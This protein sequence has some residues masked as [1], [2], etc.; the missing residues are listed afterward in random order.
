VTGNRTLQR[1]ERIL[2]LVPWLLERP[3][4]TVDEVTE[5]FGVS[6]AELAADLD[7][8]GYCGLPGYGGGDLIEASIVGDRVTVRLADY[9]RR[10]LRLSVREAVTLLLAA[11]T[12]AAVPGLRE[13]AELERAG[14]KLAG[15][16]GAPAALAIDLKAPGD[17]HL[18]PLRDAVERRRVVSLRYR[19]RSKSE[20]TE[21][22]VE[23]W[24]VVGSQGAWYLQGWC[25]LARGPRDFRLDRIERLAV[26]GADAGPVP[27]APASPPPYQPRAGDVEVVL[28][29]EQ[30]AWWLPD[31][32]V[33][34]AV[35]DRGQV[36]RVRLRTGE[37]EWL[38]RLAL[39]HGSAIRVVAP[40]S[41]RV[42][43][44]D[45]ADQTLRHYHNEAN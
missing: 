25:R 38:A 3:A 16:L 36:R 15:S 13:S 31:R 9:F 6:R 4:V 44:A 18:A 20:T 26:T 10:P 11:R 32:L 42:R 28:D 17:Q 37:L 23:P 35:E 21:R 41:L 43:L 33:V 8:L 7:V 14:A 5:R 39:A 45:L 34:D 24:A 30:A 22:D 12:L 1:L 40:D 19:S 27:D 29:L 2:V